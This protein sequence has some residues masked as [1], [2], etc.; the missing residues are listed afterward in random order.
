[1]KKFT[2]VCLITSL[3]IFL[4]GI[5]TVV[6]CGLKGGFSQIYNVVADTISDISLFGYHFSIRI[7]GINGYS[8]GFSNPIGVSNDYMDVERTRIKNGEEDIDIDDINSVYVEMGVSDII[9]LN[10]DN[11]YIEYEG[12]NLP[13]DFRVKYEN[14]VLQFLQEDDTLF[15]YVESVL[16]IYIPEKTELQEMEIVIGVGDLKAES[17]DFYAKD[18]EIELG[19]GDLY[20]TDLNS[21]SVN[22]ECGCGD[23]KVYCTNIGDKF[24]AELGCGDAFLQLPG[25]ESDYSYSV[26]AGCG[27]VSV[28]DSSVSELGSELSRS[29]DGTYISVECGCGD[30]NVEFR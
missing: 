14:G 18:V 20:M 13:G 1:M 26:E 15:N 10:A 12:E 28:G 8:F 22:I 27:E 16:T 23:M 2:K 21:G 7:P 5:G 19:V 30:V 25:E 3:I 11:D 9:I 24:E 17:V 4:L 29:G 6:G